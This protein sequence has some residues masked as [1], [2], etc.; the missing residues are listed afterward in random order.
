[1][2]IFHIYAHMYF[3]NYIYIIIYIYLYI[4]IVIIC[5]IISI[6]LSSIQLGKEHNLEIDDLTLRSLILWR[7]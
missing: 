7:K 2:H 4:Y 3:S 5:V 6:Y 1:M